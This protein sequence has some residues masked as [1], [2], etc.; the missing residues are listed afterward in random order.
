MKIRSTVFAIFLAFAYSASG[1]AIS[2]WTF[3]K[4]TPPD[5]N[6][7]ASG[8]SVN[9]DFGNGTAGGIHASAATDWTTPAG[10]GSANS[11]ASNEWVIGDSYTFAL[12]TVGFSDIFVTFDQ[13]RSGTGPN[14]FNIQYSVDGGG[15]F[16]AFDSY[17]VD[18]ANWNPSFRTSNS[19]VF[20]FS[21]ITALD[22]NPT[23]A[24]R[25][26]NTTTTAQPA[27]VAQIDNF[28]VSAGAPTFPAI[29]EPSTSA[30]IGAALGLLAI[31]HR[32][33]SRK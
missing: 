10:N 1:Q 14:I 15:S 33:K 17:S 31:A 28:F 8:P 18:E 2:Q 12:S 22:N 3:E 21:N 11:F 16:T 29:P 30:L 20:D 7:S 13:M 5:L 6:D 19:Y 26:L 24:F 25:L 27:G 9:A 32:C 4:N 23:V